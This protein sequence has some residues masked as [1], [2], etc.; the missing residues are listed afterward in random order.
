LL[1]DSP[2]S[3][4]R[5]DPDFKIGCIGWGSLLWDPRTLPMAGPFEAGGPRLPV[6]FS[7]VSLDGRVTLVIDP[8]SSGD[9]ETYC[10]LLSVTTLGE[11][12][13][14]LA[15]REKISE[16]RQNEWIG[17]QMRADRS[18]DVGEVSAATRAKIADWLSA[19]QLDALVWTALPSRAPDGAYVRPSAEQ[20][21]AHL[22]SLSG[23]ARERAEEY[24]RRAPPAVRSDN[25]SLFE[26]ELGW[27]PSSHDDQGE[28]TR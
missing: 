20:L 21:L 17:A 11:A 16:R 22:R 28:G 23:L 15:I 1:A 3:P 26:R 4:S 7:R 5:S 18:R 10:C 24:I 6:E 13:R 9:I 25:R 8:E 2:A 19:S 27:V 14:E 12:V